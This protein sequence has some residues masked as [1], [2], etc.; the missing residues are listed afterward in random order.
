MIAIGNFHKDVE[1]NPDRKGWVIGTFIEDDSI[2]H[3]DEFEVKWAEHNKGYFKEGLKTN[4]STKTVT[5]LVSGKFQINFTDNADGHLEK[6]ILSKLGD[7]VS[8]DASA[9]DHSAEALEDCL[10]VVFRW[11]SMR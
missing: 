8:Y 5:F 7:Y 2:F 4:V 6:V 10:V 3:S 11:P 1:N 9:C